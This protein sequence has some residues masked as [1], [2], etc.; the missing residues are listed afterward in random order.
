MGNYSDLS[1]I[2]SSSSNSHS[3]SSSKPS[4]ASS[5]SASSLAET[6]TAHN[7]NYLLNIPNQPREPTKQVVQSNSEIF[8]EQHPTQP[9]FD[10]GKLKAKRLS[11]R[12]KQTN[13]PLLTSDY[14]TLDELV[15]VEFAEEVVESI[16]ENSGI[17]EEISIASDDQVGIL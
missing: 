14:Q 13:I 1:S 17:D 8:N 3:S 15:G 16:S 9:R 7:V 12:L 11:P 2:P 4:T 5:K 10:G 6:L